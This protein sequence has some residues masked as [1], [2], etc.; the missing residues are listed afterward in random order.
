MSFKVRRT[1]AIASLFAFAALGA[2]AEPQLTVVDGIKDFGTVPKGEVLDWTFELKNTGDSDLEILQVQPACGCTVADYDSVIRP[3]ETGKVAASVQTETFS[4][5]ISKT[6]TILSNDPQ[7]PSAIVTIKAVVKP[8]VQAYPAGFLRYNLLHGQADKKS[9][10]LYTEE[11]EPFRIERIET[12]GTWVK[13]EYVEA[14]PSER[15]PAGHKDQ[16]QYRIMVTVG[17]P[18]APVG[19]LV[20]KVLVHTNS[21]NQSVYPISL[22]GMV[23][24]AYNVMPSVLNFG[25][26]A[27]ASMH[28]TK[29][30]KVS[31]NDRSAPAMF[32]V[33]KVETDIPAIVATEVRPTDAEGV[34]EVEVKLRDEVANG[35]LQGELKI[36][37][38]DPGT[39]VF[40]VPV[41]GTVQR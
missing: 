19:P 20:D 23:R 18:D 11:T 38:S 41:R 4:G 39:P 30:L 17:G 36:Y 2:I 29:V 1:L 5:P 25:R 33:E 12:P 7:T 8:Y 13:A 9:V 14:D 6:V 21:K 40:T 10:V 28:S 3:G 16:T 35:D 27:P 32:Q 26:V 24:P 34:Y 22:S 31:T 15:A 37:T